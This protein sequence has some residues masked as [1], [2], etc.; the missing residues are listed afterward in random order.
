MEGI[1]LNSIVLVIG[2]IAALFFL[3]NSSGTT[4]SSLTPLQAAQLAAA[5]TA[6]NLQK[7]QNST[8][9]SLLQGLLGKTQ[10][11]AGAPKSSGGGGGGPANQ[12]GGSGSSATAKNNLGCPTGNCP[13]ADTNTT[14]S[15]T[16]GLG[17]GVVEHGDGTVTVD[18]QVFCEATGQAIAD[19][20]PAPP[21]IA[22]CNGVVELNTCG[23]LDA[24]PGGV[25]TFVCQSCSGTCSSFC[26][27][28]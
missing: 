4:T 19:G 22:N 7:Q 21:D 28:C 14:T 16:S 26:S 11:S 2:G 25:A 27:G 12:A 8:L 24:P 20:P 15:V 3:R 18:G 10:P 13:I 23:G 6:A 17:A 1:E 5:Q 9:G